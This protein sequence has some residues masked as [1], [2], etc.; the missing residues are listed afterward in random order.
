MGEAHPASPSLSPAHGSEGFATQYPQSFSINQDLLA[1]VRV[2]AVSAVHDEGQAGWA[3]HQAQSRAPPT[4]HIARR[5]GK[6]LVKMHGQGVFPN[7]T[8]A[9][10]SV[11]AADWQRAAGETEEQ[12]I[13]RWVSHNHTGHDDNR[14]RQTDPE[15]CD[16]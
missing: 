8:T 7:I 6:G 14:Q 13:G 12:R 11:P 10:C 4:A 3:R 9:R 1:L 2:A 5:L 16:L 15:A